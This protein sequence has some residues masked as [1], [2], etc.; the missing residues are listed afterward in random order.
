MVFGMAF[1]ASSFVL[2]IVDERS[3]KAKH[4]QQVSGVNLSTFWLAA[5]LWDMIN[6]IVPC[7]GILILF[8]AF[9][10]PAFTGYNL[11]VV[12]LLLLEYGWSIIPLM[13]VLSYFFNKATTAFTLLVLFNVA[14]GCAAVL[15]IFMLQILEE[16]DAANAMKWVS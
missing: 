12:A 16:Y 11:G 5:F 14:T 9:Q 13:Y 4:I 15:I 3:S 8:A 7:V 2:F 1:L 10:V 6:Y